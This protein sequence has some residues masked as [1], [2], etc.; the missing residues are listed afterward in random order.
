V[1]LRGHVAA[2][3]PLREHDLLGGGQQL[4]PP[5]V[6][7]EELQ[8]V[9]RAGD[10]DRGRSGLLLFRLGRLLGLFLCGLGL[11]RRGS[12]RADLE[13]GALEFPRELFTLVVVQ[14]ELGRE[15]LELGGIDEAALLGA[16]DDGADLVRLEQFVKLV[17]RQGSLRPFVLLR[18]FESLLTLGVKS[19]DY[20]PRPYLRPPG[21]SN[22]APRKCI[23]RSARF[24]SLGRRSADEVCGEPF[25]NPC[26]GAATSSPAPSRA[27]RRAARA[28]GRA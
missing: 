11:R 25:M 9:G 2:L 1:A 21:R 8:A 28:P 26:G 13:P 18:R 22:E 24:V 20:Y 14:L 7:E 15:G 5:D 19:S 10:R 3:D 27:A 4:V 12:R 17:L 23:P 6:G 16:L